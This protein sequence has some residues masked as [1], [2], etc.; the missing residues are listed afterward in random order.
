MVTKAKYM[1]DFQKIRQELI[2]LL[3]DQKPYQ[4]M[5]FGSYAHGSPDDDSDVDLLV[6]L[7]KMGVSGSYKEIIENKKRISTRLRGLRK[8]IP[9][10][11][12]VYT[13]DE[14][15]LLKRSGS[16]FIRRIEREGIRLI[17]KT[18]QKLGR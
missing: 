10:D 4:V 7:D 8:K 2:D 17:R 5:V 16:S 12:L 11:L 1:A 3:I 6:V 13:K 9:I 14:W 15:N 18:A